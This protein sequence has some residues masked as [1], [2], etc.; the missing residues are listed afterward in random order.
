[1]IWGSLGKF[2]VFLGSR[3]HGLR[4]LKF[5][6]AGNF[7]KVTNGLFVACHLGLKID[8]GDLR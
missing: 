3:L 7:G 8:T 2:V 6:I 5:K 1:M 4:F